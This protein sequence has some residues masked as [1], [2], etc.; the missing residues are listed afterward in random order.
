MAGVAT[1]LAI[2][3]VGGVIVG[4]PGWA[5]LPGPYLVS[6]DGRSVESEGIAAAEWARDVLG[7]GNVMV[8]D[9]V[10]SILMSTYGQQEL[11]T[12]YETRLPLRRLYLVPEVGP[13]QRQIVRDGQIRYLVIDRRLS[14]GL[15]VVGHYYDRGE[16]RLLG[17]QYVP[18]DPQLLAKWDSQ[19]EVSRIFDS[20][21]IQL[22]DVSALA[23]GT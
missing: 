15:P 22:Y 14:T 1:V 11:V 7:A 17:S 21:N 19:P 5:R 6:A 4:L 13:V 12:T 9:R 23:Q 2:L 18:L 10:N 8:A 20:G 16:R 3:T